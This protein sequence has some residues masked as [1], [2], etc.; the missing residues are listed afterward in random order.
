MHPRLL[1]LLIVLANLLLMTDS[2][3]NAHAAQRSKS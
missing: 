3:Q 2:Q 1:N